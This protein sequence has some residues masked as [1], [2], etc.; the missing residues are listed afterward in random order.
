MKLIKKF[1]NYRYGKFNLNGFFVKGSIVNTKPPTSIMF[2]TN[3][4]GD[5]N[6]LWLGLTIPDCN[7]SWTIF[8]ISDF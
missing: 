4:T 2:L 1:I 6:G 8:S 7:I 3:K 5:E